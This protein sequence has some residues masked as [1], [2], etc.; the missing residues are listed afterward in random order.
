M[1]EVQTLTYTQIEDADR[2]LV[3]PA[4]ES[5]IRRA[6]A[7]EAFDPRSFVTFDTDNPWGMILLAGPTEAHV[8]DAD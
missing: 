7:H 4:M 3:S 5:V 2:S 8:I 6:K 1:G